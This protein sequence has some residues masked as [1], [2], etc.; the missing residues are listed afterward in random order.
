V[1][2]DVLNKNVNIIHRP[3]SGRPSNSK[4]DPKDELLNQRIA[5]INQ[6]QRKNIN[7]RPKSPNQIIGRKIGI[8]DNSPRNKSP[9]K[10]NVIIGRPQ[11]GREKIDKIYD[12]IEKINQQNNIERKAPNKVV[13]EKVNYEAKMLQNPIKISD[14]K[15]HYG[16][17]VNRDQIN[18]G[19]KNNFLN[20]MRV[21]PTNNHRGIVNHNNGPKIVL[22]NQRK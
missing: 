10:N 4:P 14:P 11:S 20:A 19:N 7:E 3:S 17:N 1:K 13:I 21:E 15:K 5:Q 8:T 22:I 9:P 18:V 2:P 6:I 16:A 12:R